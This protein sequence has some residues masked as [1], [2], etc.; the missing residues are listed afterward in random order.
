MQSV[1]SAP[2]Y[3]STPPCTLSAAFQRPRGDFPMPPELSSSP[4]SPLFSDL[5]DTPSL[6]HFLVIFCGVNVLACKEPWTLAV[7]PF[8][9]SCEELN[10]PCC[11]WT[12]RMPYQ[13]HYRG[14]FQ[15][16]QIHTSFCCSATTKTSFHTATA[17]FLLAY[18]IHSTL[19]SL[20]LKFVLLKS[21]KRNFS[22]TSKIAD[23]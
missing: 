11:T 18:N 16:S 2:S 21:H 10:A 5:G 3:A 22:V 6:S 9:C 13:C 14:L 4:L 23:S 12:S 19:N 15:S 1:P 17:T 7:G 8:H 20:S